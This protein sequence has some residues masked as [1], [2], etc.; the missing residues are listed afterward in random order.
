MIYGATV[1]PEYGT[2]LPT[3]NSDTGWA[4]RYCIHD[5]NCHWYKQSKISGNTIK[6][7]TSSIK[8]MMEY[9]NTLHELKGGI[10]QCKKCLN[11]T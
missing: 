11:Y 3:E 4:D 1:P 10:K 5:I 6:F 8:E 7:E 2:F 9:L